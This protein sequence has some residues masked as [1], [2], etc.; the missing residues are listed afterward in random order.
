MV[1]AR[2]VPGRHCGVEV[3]PC[4]PAPAGIALRQ[5]IRAGQGDT[6]VAKG[7]NKRKEVKKP[8]KEA[9]KAPVKVSSTNAKVTISAGKPKE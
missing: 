1:A 8:K 6:V 7:M 3:G 2:Q 9:A 4:I 5:A